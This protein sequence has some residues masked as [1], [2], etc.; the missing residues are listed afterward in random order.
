MTKPIVQWLWEQD[1]VCYHE[2][3][4]ERAW[5]RLFDEPLP[6][7]RSEAWVRRLDFGDHEY[8][9]LADGRVLCASYPGENSIGVI[10]RPMLLLV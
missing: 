8:R 7:C 4:V 10:A 2:D 6:R 9:I 3:T 1:D 5:K